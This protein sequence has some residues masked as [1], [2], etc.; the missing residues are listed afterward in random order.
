MP[1]STIESSSGF[2]PLAPLRHSAPTAVG[3]LELDSHGGTVWPLGDRPHGARD[4]LI[5]IRLHGQP[6]TLLH[7]AAP[8]GGENCAEVIEEVWKQAR[9]PFEDHVRSCRCLPMPLTFDALPGLLG[10]S[11]HS[12]PCLTPPRP[13]GRAAVV[14]CT[15][16]RGAVLQRTIESLTRMVCS[17]YEIIVVDNRPSLA[18][19]RE[20]VDRL[21]Q[22]APIRYVAEQRPGLA[23]AR[24][25]GL[26]AA[27]DAEYVA[28]TDDDV[29]AD[30]DWLGWLLAPFTECETGAVTGLVL[31]L[32]LN[33]AAEKRFELYA[34]FGKGVAREIYDLAEHRADDRFLFPYWGGMFGSGN[35]MAFRREA[36]LGVGGFDPALGAGTPTAGGEDLAA[37]TDVILA[38]GRL[39]YE[40]RSLCWHE[41]RGDEGALRNQVR[42]YGIGLTAVLWKYLT[43]DRRFAATLARTLPALTRLAKDRSAAREADRLPADLTRLE[44][45]G[46]LLGPWYYLRSRR[47]ARRNSDALAGSRRAHQS[48]SVSGADQAGAQTRT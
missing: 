39:V 30:A 14:V 26:R 20:L 38:G 46:R 43:T 27:S 41:H 37:F 9:E 7:L 32:T 36:L 44:L 33:S 2:L 34:G 24:N 10:A 6:L 35:S 12:C 17:D 11:P 8:P 28:F 13:P 29:V 47:M 31:P 21:A 42:G 48:A 16:G 4:Q 5:L 1:A 25:T 3:V 15:V 18:D 22:D 45:R 19:T 40:P 23:M